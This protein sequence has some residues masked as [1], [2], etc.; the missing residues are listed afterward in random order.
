VPKAFHTLLNGLGELFLRASGMKFS[1]FKKTGGRCEQN[2]EFLDVNKRRDQP[3]ERS[4]QCT[5]Q[6]SKGSGAKGSPFAPLSQV[7][8]SI[9]EIIRKIRDFDGQ[10]APHPKKKITKAPPTNFYP[11]SFQ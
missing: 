1:E 11:L 3:G 6:R 5:I 8:F 9:R 7:C 2:P 4:P 10:D